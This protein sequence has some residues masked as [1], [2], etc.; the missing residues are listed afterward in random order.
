[1]LSD[2]GCT[3]KSASSIRRASHH[4]GGAGVGVFPDLE[5]GKR[6]RLQDVSGEDNVTLRPQLI[7]E[8]EWGSSRRIRT[9]IN[10]GALVRFWLTAFTDIGKSIAVGNTQTCYPSDATMPTGNA[11]P[12]RRLAALAQVGPSEPATYGISAA[13]GVVMKSF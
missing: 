3:A 5:V 1:M 8:R 4:P 2:I 10:V 11:T 12:A 6:R 9:A 7:I 13:F